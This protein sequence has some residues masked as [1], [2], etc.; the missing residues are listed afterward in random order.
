MV[1]PVALA[2][3]SALTVNAL[4]LI[5]VGELDGGRLALG[6]FGRK[7]RGFFFLAY[8]LSQSVPELKWSVEG[9]GCRLDDQHGRKYLVTD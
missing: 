8:L 5:P 1:N 7:V 4:Q 3:W 6:I 9:Y 2:A